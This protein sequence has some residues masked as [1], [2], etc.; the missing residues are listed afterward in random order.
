MSIK[1]CEWIFFDVG[2]T[3]FDEEEARLDRVRQVI[4]LA[5]DKKIH[6]TEELIVQQ[7]IDSHNKLE[8]HPMKS[9][10]RNLVSGE[11]EREYILS[12]LK[13]NVDLEKPYPEAE[14]LLKELSTRYNIGIIANQIAGT[15]QRLEKHGLL[16]YITICFSSAEVG[17]SKPDIRLFQKA[18]NEAN[19]EPRRAVM[20]GDRMDNDIKPAKEL[21]MWAVLILQGT[22]RF[23]YAHNDMVRPDDIVNN[24]QGIKEIFFIEGSLEDDSLQKHRARTY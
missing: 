13:Y 23:Q 18:L 6:L 7:L 2:E 14:G 4:Q 8:R 20:I 24:L 5:K 10:V 11:E 12:H 19:C 1:E 17:L 21:G 3:L 9:A 15:S 22:A 16:K